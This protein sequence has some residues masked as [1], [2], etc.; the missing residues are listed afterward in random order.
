MPAQPV[1]ATQVELSAVFSAS[2]RKNTARPARRRALTSRAAQVEQGSLRR[3]GRQLTAARA[4]LGRA[5]AQAG[6]GAVDWCAT[7]L[8]DPRPRDMT[9]LVRRPRLRP[10]TPLWV[11]V[12]DCS[13]SMLRTGALAASKGLAG[14]I[15]VEAARAGARVVLISFRG[16]SAQLELSSRA[17]RAVVG[18][19]IAALGGGGGTPLRQALQAA[20]RCCEHYGHGPQ[21]QQRILLLTDGRSRDPVADLM[22]G[23]PEIELWV[24][25][26]ERGPVRLG[27]AA[28][29]A[30]ALCA[31][32][33]ALDQVLAAPP[34]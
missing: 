17:G 4:R 32:Y 5:R 21:P 23:H 1:R 7:L 27:F 12:L 10:V 29:L 15:E 25:D 24:V 11:L 14:A 20:L 8:R 6:H 30:A 22:V 13:A 3:H 34:A 31:S 2:L 28:P 18:Q 26:C 16:S 9:R 19:R 33:H